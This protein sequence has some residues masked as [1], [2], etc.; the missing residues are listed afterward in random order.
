MTT[1][2]AVETMYYHLKGS[3]LLSAENKITGG[4]YKLQRPL[5]SKKEDIVINA[6]PL[7]K[8]AVSR[9]ILNVNIYVPNLDFSHL[10]GSWMQQDRTQPDTKRL[11]DLAWLANRSLPE[12]WINGHTFQVVQDTIFPDGD[13]HY[14]N[15]RIEFITT[16]DF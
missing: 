3:L 10:H 4:L 8:G 7:V 11:A 16:R 13:H 15:F 12:I 9:C 6:L 14:L 5:N 1:L 2:D